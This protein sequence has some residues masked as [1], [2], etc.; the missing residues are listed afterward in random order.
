MAARRVH[1]VAAAFEVEFEQT[2]HQLR[3]TVDEAFIEPSETV[4]VQQPLL[5]LL[6]DKIAERLRSATPSRTGKSLESVFDQF[7]AD[8]RHDWCSR[9]GQSYRTTRRWVLDVFGADTPIDAITRESC[10]EFV[11]LLRRLP[12]HSDKRFAGIAVREIV[13]T[14]EGRVDVERINAANVN[15]YLV[16]LGGM[17]NWAVAEGYVASNPSKG[18]RVR[19][20]VKRRDKRIPFSAL[21]LNT[22]FWAP[23]YTGCVDDRNGY[24]RTGDQTPRRAR[25]W[26]PLIALYSGMR[27]NEIAQLD[28]ADVVCI[29]G[30][31]CFQV[32]A[33]G[34]AGDETK[35]IKTD[36]SE[37]LVPIH[38]ELIRFGFLAYAAERNRAGD[39]KLFPEVPLS[40]LGYRSVSLSRWFARFLEK[41]GAAAPRTCFHSFRHNFRDALRDAQVP[42]EIALLLGG[43]TENGP[44]ADIYG[45]GFRPVALANELN[46][47]RY[48]GLNLLHLATHPESPDALI[49]M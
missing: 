36:A 23:L 49:A 13:A 34:I 35:R 31:T 14:T 26:V 37:R 48:S 4:R 17:F 2:R 19:D 10:R 42:R 8:P 5:D 9:T 6:T 24:A 41:S 45:R 28:A 16:R 22:I 12:K 1:A 29:D 27:L 3:M 21:Q 11:E 33:G 44:I 47:V 15:A 18:L 43:W 38:D 25:F 20:P 46:K 7:L 30:V 40:P 39:E 32:E